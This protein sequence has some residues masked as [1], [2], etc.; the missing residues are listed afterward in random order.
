MLDMG[1]KACEK[2]LKTWLDE[3]NNLGNW[4]LKEKVFARISM[5]ALLSGLDILQPHLVN[6][7]GVIGHLKID[8]YSHFASGL[9]LRLV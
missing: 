5:E 3:N 6:P 8:V 2:L 1:I 4:R 9:H 7:L